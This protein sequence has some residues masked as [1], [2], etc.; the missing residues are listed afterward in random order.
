MAESIRSE[1]VDLA[2]FQKPDGRSKRQIRSYMGWKIDYASPVGEP[3]FVGPESVS[4]RVYK[5]PIALGIGGICAVLLEFADARIRSGVWD[6]SVFKVDPIGRATRTGIA[7]MV[8]VFGARESARKVINGVNKMHARVEGVTP[9]GE[10]YKALDVELLDWV[11]A[12]GGFG[13]V[14]AYDQFVHPLSEAEKRQFFCESKPI[15]K[16]YGV[17]TH[18]SSPADFDTMMRKL[19]PR[20]EPH[21]IN[22]EFLEIVKSNAGAPR[23]IQ[24]AV[25]NAAVA[26]LPV[27]VRTALALGTEYDLGTAQKIMLRTM[28]RAAEILP[29]KNSPA[30]QASERLGL[31]RNF[32]WKS[33][34]SRAGI[35][36]Q[37]SI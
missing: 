27:P 3:G 25:V 22:T 33:A 16:L 14:S 31:P 10:A 37:R 7:A 23:F 36:S 34:A 20:F 35:L 12:T 24:A 29:V 26:I 11:F 30:A 6:H 4:W 13:F 21:P 9:S 17:E 15:G 2:E 18:V 28:A 32:P 19:L 8:G 1:D 5:N